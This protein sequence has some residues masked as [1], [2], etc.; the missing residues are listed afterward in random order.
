MDISP[1]IFLTLCARPSGATTD[2]G[3]VLVY[4]VNKE[5]SK[6]TWLRQLLILLM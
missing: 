5:V 1:R 4:W 3:K 6:L 2:L